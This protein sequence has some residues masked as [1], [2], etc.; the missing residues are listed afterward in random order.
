MLSFLKKYQVMVLAGSLGVFAA[1]IISLNVKES[2]NKLFLFEKIIYEITSP[3]Q[4]AIKLSTKSVKTLWF[5]YVFLINLKNENAALKETIETLTR[6]NI[7]LKEALIAN[8]RLRKLLHFKEKFKTP[9]MPA[10]VIAYDPSMWFKTVLI[11]KGSKDGVA[12]NMAVVTSGGIVGRIMEVSRST[13]KLLL[14][15]DHRSA[16]DAIVQRTRA[17]GILVGK[18]DDRCLLKYVFR[19]DDVKVR[20][21]II[22]S[23]LGGIFPKG[24]PLGHISRVSKNVCGMFQ[25]VEVAPSVAFTKLE[26][27]FIVVGDTH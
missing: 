24:L 9:M 7:E 15:T 14:I 12:K 4:K 3:F 1:L 13:S 6:E 8:T 19:A 5:N 22:S 25:N 2:N 10:E 26:E 17:K 21:R 20:D 11:D 27:V 18:V 16:V 23:G